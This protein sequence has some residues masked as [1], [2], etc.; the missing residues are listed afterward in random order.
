MV[1]ECTVKLARCRAALPLCAALAT[2]MLGGCQVAYLLFGQGRQ[3][4]AFKLPKD[5]RVLVLVDAAPNSG[6]PISLP[7]RLGRR[8][9]VR[10]FH[11][12]VETDFV[13]QYRVMALR[14]AVP[15]FAHWSIAKVAR[16]FDT[17]LVIYVFVR[18]FTVQLASDNQVTDGAATAEV[19]VVSADGQRLWPV[20]PPGEHPVTAVVRSGLARDQS[21]SQVRSHLLTV[22]ARRTSQLFYSYEIRSQPRMPHPQK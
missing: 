11:H 14:R 2:L 5:V 7:R 19:K 16:K 10:L 3:A 15:A 17:N 22:L 8:I 6:M 20:R 12:K 4:A 18:H 13:P 9:A 1:Q 21:V